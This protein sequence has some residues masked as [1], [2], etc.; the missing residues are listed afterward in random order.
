MQINPH[1]NKGRTL[2]YIGAA[3]MVIS[4]GLGANP[5]AWAIA[6]SAVVT[7]YTATKK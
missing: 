6:L 3:I 2:V 1:E 5:P 4:I 7:I